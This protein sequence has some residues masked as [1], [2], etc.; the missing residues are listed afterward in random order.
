MVKLLKI[1]H[2]NTLV[3]ISE[4]GSFHAAALRVHLSAA[5]ISTQMA[6]LKE[7]LG[8]DI[9]SSNG[10]KQELTPKGEVILE[11]ARRILQI[12]HEA[13]SRV[14]LDRDLE[15]IHF[16]IPEDYEG[17]LLPAILSVFALKHPHVS[18]H[19]EREPSNSLY[20]LLNL[21]ALD[22][23][24]VTRAPDHD[25]AVIHKMPL[26]WVKA[27]NFRTENRLE[28]P[29]A[30]FQTGF[31]SHDLIK[32]ALFSS[33]RP[34]R[35]AYTSP[36]LSGIIGVVRKGLAIAALARCCVPHDLEIISE[37][38]MH[39]PKLPSLDLSVHFKEGARS[40]L[41]DAFAEA[42]YANIH[43]L[44]HSDSAQK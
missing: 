20:N 21:R 26:V 28:L 25:T 31:Q 35:I 38:E 5:A 16:G 22:L 14:G 23:A 36:S 44:G 32:Q 43:V 10:R 13:F 12:N 2:L 4:T 8:V 1:D 34:F 6:Q 39:L 37:Q 19:M 27:S 7:A 42:I 15:T 3:A 11:C 40:P 9:F 30:L 18:I 24:V 33:G 17:T 29:L 41:I